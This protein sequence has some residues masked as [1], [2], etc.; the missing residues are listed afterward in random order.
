MDIHQ[1]VPE[2]VQGHPSITGSSAPRVVPHIR[3][4]APGQT[5]YADGERV[6]PLPVDVMVPA[7][8]RVFTPGD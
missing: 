1:D 5:A 3:V 4:D 8:L 2:G 6:R 7:G